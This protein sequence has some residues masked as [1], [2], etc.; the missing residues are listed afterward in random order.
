MQKRLSEIQK[1][2]VATAWELS[3]DGWTVRDNRGRRICS[4]F[5]GAGGGAECVKQVEDAERIASAP[6][7]IQFLL[8]K[9]DEYRVEA[10]RCRALAGAM[11][12]GMN[13]SGVL[14]EVVG[15]TDGHGPYI[16]ICAPGL[17]EHNLGEAGAQMIHALLRGAG[18]SDTAYTVGQSSV[19][20]TN[21]DDKDGSEG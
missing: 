19:T 1:R 5:S 14:V 10:R 21:S 12:R 13:T 3:T 7:D 6:E 20:G 17:N 16:S 2:W 9:L 15:K 4:T 18:Y 8:A 11:L